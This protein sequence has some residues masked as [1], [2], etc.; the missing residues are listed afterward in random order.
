MLGLLGDLAWDSGMISNSIT[1]GGS[2]GSCGASPLLP[3]SLIGE[4]LELVLEF[5]CK[6]DEDHK[7][8]ESL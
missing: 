3:A 8:D 5:E 1:G 2:K 4:L 6:G 7:S